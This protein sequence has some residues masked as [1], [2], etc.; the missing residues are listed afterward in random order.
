[1]I[2]LVPW[3]FMGLQALHESGKKDGLWSKS[4]PAALE[5]QDCF[6][7]LERRRGFGKSWVRRLEDV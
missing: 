3:P 2:P 6:T 5:D 4:N 1:M 7:A